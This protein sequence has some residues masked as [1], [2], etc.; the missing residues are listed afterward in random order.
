[1][2]ISEFAHSK[3][4]CSARGAQDQP[5]ISSVEASISGVRCVGNCSP[6]SFRRCGISCCR[7]R[8]PPHCRIRYNTLYALS[9]PLVFT[10]DWSESRLGDGGNRAGVARQWC[11]R[12]KGRTAAV[13]V[14]EGMD[15]LGVVDLLTCG[16]DEISIP[17]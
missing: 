10:L 1:V 2:S 12:A 3:V 15:H 16:C 6:D 4:W 7:G 13:A 5:P 8:R 14:S 9:G 11:R 17:F